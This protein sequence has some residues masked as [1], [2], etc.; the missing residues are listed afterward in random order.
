[1]RIARGAVGWRMWVDL[2]DP[3]YLAFGHYSL[4]W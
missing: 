3:P 1:M 4:N 2:T